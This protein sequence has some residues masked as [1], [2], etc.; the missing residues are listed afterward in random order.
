MPLPDDN[1]F[2][3]RQRTLNPQECIPQAGSV[4]QQNSAAGALLVYK[5]P[6]ENLENRPLELEIEGGFD[7]QRGEP[8]KLRYELDF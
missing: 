7:I 6:V 3:Y 4:A 2:A 8:D 1:A 5:I